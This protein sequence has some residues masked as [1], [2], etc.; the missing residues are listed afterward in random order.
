MASA[1][2]AKP[3]RSAGARIATR[4]LPWLVTIACFTFLYTRLARAAGPDRGV[5]AYLLEVFASVSW[6]RWLVLMVAYSCFYLLVD[7]MVLWRVINWFNAKISFREI[8][9]VRASTYIISIL[10]EQVGKGAIALYLNRRSGV[11]GW[12]L[13]SSMLFIMACELYYLLLWATVGLALH[14]NDL[15]EALSIFRVVPWVAA[16]ATVL[17]AGVI[18]AFRSPRLAA[19]EWRNRRILHAFR[20]A[21]PWQY[22]AILLLRSP[23]LLAG[24]LVY[25][26]AAGL[27]GVDI[28]FLRMLTYFPLVVFG[29]LVPGPFRAVAVTMW[30]TLFPEH[31]GQMAVFGF[32]QHNFF[33]LF[34]AVIGLLFL[35][36]TNRELF[37]AEN[38]G[39]PAVKG[40]VR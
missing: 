7:T 6:S 9:P 35:R 19:A 17:A 37:D 36:K 1:A 20:E 4:V 33:V 28:P 22:G 18:W 23:S 10:N 38:P 40:V 15:P 12:E 14:W 21:K 24:V 11:P 25:S 31:A 34:N 32:V 2:E 29:A 30:P 13:G 3:P 26:I 27:F 16:G 5:A 8:L 39:E